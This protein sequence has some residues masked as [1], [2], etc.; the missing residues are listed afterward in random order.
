MKIVI[1]GGTGFIGRHLVWRLSGDGHDVV[2]TGR[3]KRAADQVAKL[4]QA[5]ARWQPLDH[6][7]PDAYADLLQ[8]S[9]GAGAMVHC[10]ALSSPWGR[11][12]DF[13][14]A[15]VAGTMEALRVCEALKIRRM[16]HISSPS[17][18]FLYRDRLA[19]TEDTPL[20]PPVNLYAKTKAL[21]ELAVRNSPLPERIILRPRAV[22]GPWDNTLMP[23]LERVLKRGPLP[24][25]RNGHALLDLT[26]IDNLIDGIQLALT[27]P[28]LRPLSVYNLSNGEPIRFDA[29]LAA[30][31]RHFGWTV[32]TRPVPWIVMRQVAR[33]LE[34]HALI[35]GKGEPLITQYGAGVLAFSQT[36]DLT[37]IRNELGYRPRL[38]IEQGMANHAAWLRSQRE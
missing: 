38:T 28:L 37:A 26:Y 14:S 33:L 16:I 15:N 12:E 13:Y 36:L 23:R 30:I 4:S 35:T 1:T 25:L 34:W 29:L 5:G 18:Y 2:F 19:I 20:P 24:L 22:F 8:A 6:G 21:A 32:R 9:I 10:A 7:G 17:I 3:N 31:T 11:K 27:R